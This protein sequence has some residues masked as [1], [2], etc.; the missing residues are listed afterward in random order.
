MRDKWYRWSR[1]GGIT[2]AWVGSI[3]VFMLFFFF[4]GAFGLAWMTHS[5]SQVAADAGGIAA[6]KKLEELISLDLDSQLEDRLKEGSFE[7]NLPRDSALREALEEEVP[8]E[9]IPVEDKLNGLFEGDP[10]KITHYLEPF[11][12]HHREEIADTVRYYVEKNGGD[13]E[14]VIIF[15]VNGRVEV[16]A[17]TP[18]HPPIFD[19]YIDEEYVDGK[20]YGPERIYLKLLPEKSFKIEY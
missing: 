19:E 16:Q 18:F 13:D 1:K 8:L 2:T 7:E 3:P 12:E 6:T 15:P 17:R 11:F 5:N 14:G 10:Y 9:E 4:L 20:G